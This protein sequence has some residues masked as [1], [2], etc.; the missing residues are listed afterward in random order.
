[1]CGVLAADN[2]ERVDGYVEN[3]TANSLGLVSFLSI[4]ATKFQ[5]NLNYRCLVK[6]DL[7]T[8]QIPYPLQ[9]KV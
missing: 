8:F 4:Y 2:V 1:M 3:V 9:L 7:M 6:N 5:D